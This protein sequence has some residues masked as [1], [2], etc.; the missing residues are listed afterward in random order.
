MEIDWRSIN[1][2]NRIAV[3]PRNAVAQ[4]GFVRGFLA[5]PIMQ[6]T[7]QQSLLSKNMPES[8]GTH[9]ANPKG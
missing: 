2:G 6:I 5:L 8:L 7:S 3:Q 9:S 1:H 4:I